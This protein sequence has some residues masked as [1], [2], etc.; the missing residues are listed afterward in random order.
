[1]SDDIPEVVALGSD[2][3]HFWDASDHTQR[4]VVDD[5]PP[6]EAALDEDKEPS[7]SGSKKDP[8]MTRKL[9]Y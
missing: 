1:M 5:P 6:V 8:E 2:H 9:S 4:P 7:P 3:S